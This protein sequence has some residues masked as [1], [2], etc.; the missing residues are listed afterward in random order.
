MQS[1]NTAGF[2]DMAY[3]FWTTQYKVRIYFGLPTEEKFENIISSGK[4]S[5]FQNFSNELGLSKTVDF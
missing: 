5:L 3:Y 2:H 1:I 4:L